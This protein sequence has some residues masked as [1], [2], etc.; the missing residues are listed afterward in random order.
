MITS[1]Q[2]AVAFY[3]TEP[4]TGKVLSRELRAGLYAKDG[5]QLSDIHS[6]RFDLT[7][8]NAREREVLVRFVLSCKADEVNNQT[9]YLK[10]EEPEPGTSFYKEY[11]TIPYQLR[12]SFTTDFDL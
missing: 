2:I 10:L 5:T 12:R 6:L 11:K 7:A 1:G 3:Q 9:I 8:E 4:V